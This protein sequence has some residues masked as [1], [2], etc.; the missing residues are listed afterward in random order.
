MSLL[1]TLYRR[2][3]HRSLLLVLLVCVGGYL[4]IY[5]P[6]PQQVRILYSTCE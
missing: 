2:V 1:T 3:S 6:Q 4:F 5:R